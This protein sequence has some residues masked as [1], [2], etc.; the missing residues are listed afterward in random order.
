MSATATQLDL[1]TANE[2]LALYR[3]G[4]ASPV[5][6]AQAVLARIEKLNPAL[7][8]FCHLAPD[9]TL[10]SAR[11]SEARWRAGQPC[12][13]LDGVPVSIQDLILTRHW[14]TL[15][16]CRGN[17]CVSQTRIRLCADQRRIVVDRR[18]ESISQIGRQAGC[19][20]RQMQIRRRTAH[21]A[22]IGFNRSRHRALRLHQLRARLSV[23]R[24]RLRHVSASH[25][26][27]I[28]LRLC[29]LLQPLQ[30]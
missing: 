8:A 13:A 4:D 3:S 5:E 17:V 7:N 25:H 21:Q 18:G 9:D 24:L 2:L 19:S 10:N 11:A 16:G 26:A 22:A 20:R 15:R 30:V 14:P 23:A 28:E 12:G 27:R 29:V 6:T 1:C